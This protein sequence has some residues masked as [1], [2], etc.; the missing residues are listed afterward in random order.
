MVAQWSWKFW[1]ILRSLKF[2]LVKFLKLPNFFKVVPASDFWLST[3]KK[4]PKIALMTRKSIFLAMKWFF[5][6]VQLSSIGLSFSIRILPKNYFWIPQLKKNIF[7]IFRPPN[8][9]K[10]FFF[11]L[12][13]SMVQV[14]CGSQ[15][16]ILE[17]FFGCSKCPLYHMS[18]S[19]KKISALKNTVFW[20]PPT[21]QISN[22]WSPKQ[23]F[24]IWTYGIRGT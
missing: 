2:V 10:K 8:F 7:T 1:N 3:L 19:Q 6:R 12:K 21:P 4:G 24:E 13:N 23:I 5:H 22:F 11:N 17:H 15:K 18:I 14:G 9:E 20:P 16:Y